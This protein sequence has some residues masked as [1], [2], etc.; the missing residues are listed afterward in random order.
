MTADEPFTG[1][2]PRSSNPMSIVES[3]EFE[4]PMPPTV[5]MRALEGQLRDGD[6]AIKLP[7]FFTPY[8]FKYGAMHVIRRVSDPKEGWVKVELEGDI[9]KIEVKMNRSGAAEVWR[10]GKLMR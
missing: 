2:A 6:H 1:P 5:K 8:G 9:D 3:E 4:A 7:F 10:N